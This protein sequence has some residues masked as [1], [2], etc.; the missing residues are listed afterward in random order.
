MVVVGLGLGFLSAT[1]PA[2]CFAPVTDEMHM[3]ILDGH[4]GGMAGAMPALPRAETLPKTSLVMA[5]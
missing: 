4:G 3:P 2:R 1:R 5:S